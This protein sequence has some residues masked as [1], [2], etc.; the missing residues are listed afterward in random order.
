MKLASPSFTDGGPIPSKF[1]CDGED[2]SP[3]LE[4]ADVP[5][6]AK[7][8]ALIV[9]DPDAPG[10][11]WLHWLVYDMTR[12][13]HI[14]EGGVPGRQGMNDFGKKDYGGPC[15]P[16]GQHRYFF[17]LHALDTELSLQEGASRADVEE[18]MADH[19]V[20]KAELVGLYERSK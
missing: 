18:A 5:E 3:A 19:V 15:P 16:S 6:Q 4:I 20:A 7:T 12:R 17:R 9:D 1:T 10:K 11:T 14:P 8:L 2:V 13:A